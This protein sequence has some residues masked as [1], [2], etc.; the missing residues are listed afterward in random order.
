MTYFYLL[1][2]NVILPKCCYQVLCLDNAKCMH[3]VLTIPCENGLHSSM[4]STTGSLVA[5]V[6]GS[7]GIGM[8]L[9]I[10]TYAWFIHT[11]DHQ[12]QFKL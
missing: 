2:Y 6:T 7:I 5:R 11:Y 1:P 12:Y 4:E 9:C 3:V 10:S 8:L